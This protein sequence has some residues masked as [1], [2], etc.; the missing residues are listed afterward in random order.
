LGLPR[1]SRWRFPPG[2]GWQAIGC[3]A[4]QRTYVAAIDASARAL[5]AWWSTSP[6]DWMIVPRGE[7]LDAAVRKVASRLGAN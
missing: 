7:L 1:L 6:H 2:P 5:V 3:F 4:P